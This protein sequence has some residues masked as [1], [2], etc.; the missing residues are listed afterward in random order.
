MYQIGEKVVYG[1]HGVCIV[2][3]R[4]ERTVDRKRVT[5]LALEP[6]GQ[7]GSRYLVPTHNPAA[8]G[9]IRRMLS[10]EEL[11]SLLDSDHIHADC[12]ILDENQRKQTYRDL[13][14]SGD[15]ARLLQMVYTLYRHRKAQTAAGRKCHLCDENFLR[16]AEKLLVGEF[17][18]VLNMEQDQAKQYIRSRL[19]ENVS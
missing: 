18:Q 11:E 2:V 9:K 19:K 6:V 12:W 7:D 14:V 15:R 17:A 13:I 3:D 4:E 1:I 10:K 16:D 5:Y 8:M